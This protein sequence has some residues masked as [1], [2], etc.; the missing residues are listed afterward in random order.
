MLLMGIPNSLATCENILA[1][2]YKIK[3]HLVYDWAL[4]LLDVCPRVVKTYVHI[5]KQRLMYKCSNVTH[6]HPGKN[7]NIHQQVKR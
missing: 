2:S 4:P 3:T 1:G 6:N 7:A 5:C